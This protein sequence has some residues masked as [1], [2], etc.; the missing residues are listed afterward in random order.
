MGSTDHFHE[1]QRVQRPLTWFLVG[2]VALLLVA[3]AIVEAPPPAYRVLAV[4]VAAALVAV[5]AETRLTTEVR[6]DGV[7]IR[8]APFRRPLVVPFEDLQRVTLRPYRPAMPLGHWGMHVGYGRTRAYNLTAE[9]GVMLTYGSADA[10]DAS[11]SPDSGGRLETVVVGT[12]HADE[13]IAA[14]RRA[15]WAPVE[16]VRDPSE[17]VGERRSRPSTAA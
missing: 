4:F 2:G 12:D 6:D 17:R 8:L 14:I 16:V 7:H 13:F 5:T 1:V 15:G 9:H 10:F 11:D 3:V